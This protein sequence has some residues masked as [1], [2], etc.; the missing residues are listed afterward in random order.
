[1]AKAISFHAGASRDIA[2]GASEPCIAVLTLGASEVP[3]AVTNALIVDQ[4]H[5]SS[6]VRAGS[7]VICAIIVALR[8]L[9][10]SASA[11]VAGGPRD[12]YSAG[13]GTRS[14]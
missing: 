4:F 5:P 12:S 14:I 9:I 8:P 7:G 3:L 6:A 10:V 2:I 11:G 13:A 1:M